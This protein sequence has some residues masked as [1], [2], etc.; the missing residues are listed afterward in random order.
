MEAAPQPGDHQARLLRGP[1]AASSPQR[2]ASAVRV[3]GEAGAELAV[4]ELVEGAKCPHNPDL[5]R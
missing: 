5:K 2:L 4:P 1:A 3:A